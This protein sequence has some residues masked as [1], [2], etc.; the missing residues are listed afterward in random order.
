MF[1][2]KCI[3]NRV[4]N[5]MK[6]SKDIKP[7]LLKVTEMQDVQLLMAIKWQSHEVTPL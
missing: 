1:I 4:T 3:S 7:L 5:T 6:I 2:F